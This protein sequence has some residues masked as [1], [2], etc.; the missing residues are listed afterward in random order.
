MS[1]LSTEQI[2]H[3]FND[4]WLFKDL[5]FGLLKGDRVALVGINGT[6]KSTLLKILAE[7]FPPQ[8]GK[9]VKERGIKIG[10]LPQEPDFT[11]LN[12]INDFIFSA[13]NEQQQLIKEYE[14]LLSSDDID[15]KKL[16]IL[17]DQLTALDAWEYEYNIKTILNRL[18]I[19]NFDQQIESLSGGQKKRLSLAKLLIDEPDVYILDEPTNHLDIETIEWLEKLMTTGQKTVLLVSHDRYFLDSVCTEIREL[20]KGKLFT[21]KG[22]YAY[23]LEK[24]AEREYNDVLSADK[25][26]NLL[27]KEL[28]WMRRQPKARG[29]KSKARIEAFYDLEEKSKGPKSQDKVKLSVKVSRQGS[30]ILELENVSKGFNN[31]TIINDFSYTF[32]KGD[33]IGL[34]GK[35]GSG[36]STFLNLITAEILPDS[37]TVEIGETTKYGYYHQGGLQFNE[38]DRVLD[39]VKNVADYIQMAN[40]DTLTASQLLTLFLFPPEKQF[41]L[42]SKLSGGEKKRLQLMR[43]LMANPNFLILDEPSNDL[44]IDTLNVLEEFLLNY[45]GVLILVSHDRYLIDKLT[46]Q[47]F[48]FDGNGQVTIYNGNYAD[49]KYEEELRLKE[50]KIAEKAKKEFKEA[51]PI[52]KEEKKILSYKEQLEYESLEKQIQELEEKIENKTT[53]LNN[54]SDHT[55]LSVLAKDIEDLQ[56]SL[57]SKS[58]RWLELAELM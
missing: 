16:E 29:T 21:Y 14:E 50:E 53:E 33:R 19:S 46:E 58:E 35:N 38:G 15:S 26:R 11:G 56:N 17:T 30:K 28:E 32:K 27:T 4:K 22:N 49:F 37:G 10:Y 54:T 6:G 31:R 36:K 40:G 44:D 47:L 13:D 8:S 51:A 18:S 45:P 9:V 7:I 1:I 12:T 23:F 41:G 24:K 52:L 5:H 42:I 25:A 20:D 43:V 39:V 48:I 2:A 34:A 3:S 55:S 57:D